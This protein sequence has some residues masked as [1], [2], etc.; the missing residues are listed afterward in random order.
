MA[1]M[2]F[3]K[4][5]ELVVAGK[6]TQTRRIVKPGQFAAN[7]WDY[8]T[9]KPCIPYVFIGGEPD[10][11]LIP[12]NRICYQYKQQFAVMPAR[13]VRGIRKVADI[14]ITR[15]RREDVRE[16]TWADAKAEGF[17]ICP[18][19][20]FWRTWC[21]MHDA[22]VAGQLDAE[23]EYWDNPGNY[24]PDFEPNL[25]NLCRGALSLRPTDRYQSWALDFRVLNVYADAVATARELL[26]AA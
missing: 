26:A 8:E 2:L 14:E 5:W 20:S 24:H 19:Y 13:G 18:E 21:S 25:N 23:F 7:G 1:N 17:N 12:L 4:T 11:G 15:I 6:K 10:G 3:V 16:I 9:H 22:P